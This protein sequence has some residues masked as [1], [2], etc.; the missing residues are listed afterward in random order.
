MPTI[1]LE[2]II[3]APIEVVF[4]LSRNISVHAEA[5]KEHELRAIAGVTSSLINLNETVTW[6]AKHFGFRMNHTSK[7]IAMKPPHSFADEMIKGMFDHWHHLH[8]FETL[9][10]G[11]TK[12]I[13]LID[14]ASPLGVLGKIVDAVYLKDYM[15]RFLIVHNEHIKKVAEGRTV[16]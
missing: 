9:E 10:D 4:D 2:T 13:D 12:M 5:D 6:E 16:G 8:K 15:T 7:I 11:R 3:A 14:Y 1:Y